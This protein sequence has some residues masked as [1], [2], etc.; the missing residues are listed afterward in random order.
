[1]IRTSAHT[2]GCP[3]GSGRSSSSDLTFLFAFE[4]TLGLGAEGWKRC[5]FGAG[6]R[7][8]DGV[9]T[10][11]SSSSSMSAASRFFGF[12]EKDLAWAPELF[13][14]TRPVEDMLSDQ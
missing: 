6:S 3:R 11:Y 8:D 1:M 10:S 5:L 9:T 13:S 14:I 4:V 2:S 7:L 12:R